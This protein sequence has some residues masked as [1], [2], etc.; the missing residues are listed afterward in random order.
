MAGASLRKKRERHFR[1]SKFK[2]CR[3]STYVQV[4]TQVQ[5]NCH[6]SVFAKNRE[7]RKVGDFL[8]ASCDFSQFFVMLI[9]TKV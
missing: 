5:K 3:E 9:I 7:N 1:G 6:F 8:K 2:T 4:C